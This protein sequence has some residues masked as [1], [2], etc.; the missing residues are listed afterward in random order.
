MVVFS[1]TE[2]DKEYK[3]VNTLTQ[4]AQV[5]TD[6]GLSLIG[7]DCFFAEGALAAPFIILI[8]AW[9]AAPCLLMIFFT[10]RCLYE[11]HTLTEKQ[12]Q[13]RD[14]TAKPVTQRVTTLL[15]APPPEGLE[16]VDEHII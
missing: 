11:P 6:G 1:A 9:V 8:V 10:A 2:L 13:F 12:R 4:A 16:D 3:S 7:V 5:T 14:R 15:K